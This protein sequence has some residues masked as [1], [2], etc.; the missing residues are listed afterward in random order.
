MVEVLRGDF[1]SVDRLLGPPFDPEANVWIA[2]E[3]LSLRDDDSGTTL[4]EKIASGSVKIG[5]PPPASTD[6]RPRVSA[7][8][9]RMA[10]HSPL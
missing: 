3:S 6:G 7:K 2:P 4:A 1:E 5:P 8:K 10:S 9:R